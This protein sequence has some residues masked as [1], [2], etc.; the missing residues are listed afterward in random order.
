MSVTLRGNLEDQAGRVDAGV[1]D[2]A[3]HVAHERRGKQLPRRHVHAQGQRA[4]RAEFALPAGE[5]GARFL[6]DPLA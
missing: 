2:G 3:P 5:L 6:Q 1:A 4:S